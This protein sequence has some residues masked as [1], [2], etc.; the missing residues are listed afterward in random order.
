MVFQ[1][2]WVITSNDVDQMGLVKYPQLFKTSNQCVEDLME[3]IGYPYDVMIEH[4]FGFPIVHAEADYKRFIESG[5]EVDL[6]LRAEPG[7]QS[8]RFT[9][10][11][12]V[13][14]QL[15]FTVTQKH[16]MVEINDVDEY[17]ATNLPYDLRNELRSIDS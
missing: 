4:G 2:V 14:E 10:S 8:V 12:Y 6:E 1:D 3:Q 15:A 17:T 11:G 13:D 5:E 9:S 16:A 7:D